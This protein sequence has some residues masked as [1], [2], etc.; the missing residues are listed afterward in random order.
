MNYDVLLY[1]LL[2]PPTVLVFMAFFKHYK[3]FK[4]EQNSDSDV[5]NF[6]FLIKDLDKETAVMLD[7]LSDES[8]F[9]KKNMMNSLNKSL[10]ILEELKISFPKHLFED[11]STFET[12]LSITDSLNST[13]FKLENSDSI[14]QDTVSTTNEK[15]DIYKPS[16]WKIKIDSISAAL[17]SFSNIG[18]PMQ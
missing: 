3:R 1:L 12:I 8:K 17:A 7:F 2:V 16:E 5:V 14:N 18:Q 9:D 15:E 4:E 11:N 10:E 6:D 13:K